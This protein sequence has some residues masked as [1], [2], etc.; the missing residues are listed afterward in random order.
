MADSVQVE[1]IARMRTTSSRRRNFVWDSDQD[2]TRA[3][4]WD[5][6]TAVRRWPL[7][8]RLGWQD[9]ML[10]YRRSLIG[11][12]WLTLSMG[13]MVAAVGL[14]YGELF[15]VDKA[16]YL[17]FLT[18]GLLV[19][20]LISSCI[21]EGCQ[22]F[23]EA[24]WLILQINTPLS[25]FPIRVIWR[26]LIVFLHNVVIYVLV[27]L[28]FG[29]KLSWIT[30][31]AIPGLMLIIVNG[32]WCAILLGMLSARFRDLPQIVANML[33]ITFFAT[34]IFWHAK[35]ITT[36]IV[37]TANPFYHFI[38]VVRAPLL[39]ETPSLLSWAVVGAVTVVGSSVTLIVFRR[40]RHRISV[41]I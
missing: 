41:W 19:W 22:S 38:E 39:G 15:K 13:I 23:I 24:Q 28:I 16:T 32:F 40:F 27:V 9:V 3:V 37:V 30:F 8:I 12:F 2:L 17:P 5:F 10:R 34:P 35:L 7:W 6:S 20:G 4:I 1:P 36:K 14:I 11:P 29:V 21:S 31:A 25:M 33:Q 26:N 18:I